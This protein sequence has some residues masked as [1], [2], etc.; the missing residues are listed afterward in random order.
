VD[1]ELLQQHDDRKAAL[2]GTVVSTYQCCAHPW[3]PSLEDL[4]TLTPS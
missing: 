4:P 2:H 1:K 3:T